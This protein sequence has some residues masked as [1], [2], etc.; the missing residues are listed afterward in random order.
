MNAFL[1]SLPGLASR[2]AGQVTTALVG[3]FGAS[4]KTGLSFAASQLGLERLKEKVRQALA[5]IPAKVDQAIR[6]AVTTIA[7]NV[8]VALPWSRAAGIPANTLADPNRFQV[9]DKW[10]VLYT[11]P[12]GTG[13][14]GR[15]ELAEEVVGGT[16]RRIGP[17]GL[18]ADAFTTFVY[19]GEGADGK[20][21]KEHITALIQAALRLNE[22]LKAPAAPGSKNPVGNLVKLRADVEA[23]ELRVQ[24]DIE[25]NACVALQTGCFAA[26]TKLL[27]RDGWRAVEDIRV[28]DEVASRSEFDPAAD[29]EWKAVEATFRR[30]GYI[31]HLHLG[32][33]VIRTT[34]EHP[35]YV[36][37]KGWVAA[38]ALKPGDKLATLSGE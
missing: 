16:Y 15:V 5:A 26:G 34:P 30:T 33:Q 9:G 28:G 7:A 2:N 3:A 37:D 1:D 10:Y 17:A 4:V 14:G 12:N 25:A 8:A 13:T 18:T 36:R 23:A 31:L 27:T 35:F 38:G 21:A 29:V 24:R 6:T 22:A 19:T 20:S 11:I 32:G